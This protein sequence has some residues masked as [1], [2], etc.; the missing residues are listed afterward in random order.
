MIARVKRDRCPTDGQL[1]AAADAV[2]GDGPVSEHLSGCS[3]CHARFE[4]IVANAQL[5]D[6]ALMVLETSRSTPDTALALSSL[7]ARMYEKKHESTMQSGG[8]GM[9]GTW[10]RSPV[11]AATA[12]VAVLAVVMAVSFSPMRTF[13]D[14]L[15]NQ[16]RVQ[17]FAA[18]TIPMDMIAPMQMMFEA[19]MSEADVEAMKA[20]LTA[21]GT[22]DS[23]FGFDHETM[24]EPLTV[25]EAQ[26]AY[27]SFAIPGKLPDGFAATPD[28]YVTEAGTASYTMDVARANEI[29]SAIGLPIFSLP[30]PAVY[31]T[32]TFTLNAPAAVALAY[33]N[34]DGEMLLAG[35]MASPS[36]SIPD[37][38]DMNALREDILRFPGLPTDFVAELRA[39]DDWENTLIIPIP[40]G[41]T[42]RDVTVNGEPGLLIESDEG[43]VVL[44]EDGGILYGVGGQVSGS[45][46]LSVANSMD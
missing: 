17:K 38:V 44:W 3:R 31:P 34:T 37:G 4:A 18:I 25:E 29:V 8:Q 7:R 1:R 30:D 14:D 9:S 45:E 22:F 2:H 13:A 24:P 5:A 20:E 41:A 28:A 21:L 32:V 11:R 40:E 19:S 27:G 35:Q 42:S 16:F 43:S 36:L 15:L 10:R 6:N 23:T 12:L 33:T 26:A 46:A 39:I